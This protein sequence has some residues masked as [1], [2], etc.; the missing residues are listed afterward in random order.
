MSGFIFLWKVFYTNCV[1]NKFM[2]ENNPIKNNKTPTSKRKNN[3]NLILII[4]TAIIVLGILVFILFIQSKEE[5]PFKDLPVAKQLE[6]VEQFEKD[7]GDESNYA[8]ALASNNNYFCSLI[9]DNRLRRKCFNE[10]S[11][12]EE[13]VID[14]R[15]ETNLM[16]ESNYAG[17]L[18]SGDMSYCNNIVDEVL[19]SACLSNFY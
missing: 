12:F 14:T 8:G 4:G 15:T 10:I 5:I 7:L 3:L 6:I 16:D 13:P 9:A 19:K 1:L 2:A 17:A 11:N 18:A